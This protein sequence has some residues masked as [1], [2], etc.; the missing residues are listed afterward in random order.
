MS[1][2]GEN[3]PTDARWSRTAS[4]RDTYGRAPERDKPAKPQRTRALRGWFTKK[5]RAT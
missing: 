1:Q 4:F 2:P 5:R 3:P